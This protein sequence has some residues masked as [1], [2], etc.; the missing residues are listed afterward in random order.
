MAKGI[1]DVGNAFLSAADGV[2]S[3]WS[4]PARTPMRTS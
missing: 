3:S 4:R 1:S 2:G